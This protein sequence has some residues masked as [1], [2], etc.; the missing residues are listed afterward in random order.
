LY[1][2]Y[3]IIYQVG[4]YYETKQTNNNYFD[5][6]VSINNNQIIPF[7]VLIVIGSID[8]EIQKTDWYSF[9]PHLEQY[10]EI[11]EDD[12]LVATPDIDGHLWYKS[13]SIIFHIL[14]ITLFDPFGNR[15]SDEKKIIT[16]F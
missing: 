4:I 12:T 9:F 6:D 8:V 3:D 1:I 16:F 13:S 14:K 5:A 15:F 7:F 11:Y 10:V 2:I